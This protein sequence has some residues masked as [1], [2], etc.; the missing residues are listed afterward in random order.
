M[1]E[2]FGFEFKRKG[3]KTEEDIGSFAPKI[4]DEGAITVAEGGAYGT[5]VDLEG[6]TRTESELITRY[7][8][9]ALQPECELAIDDIVNETIVYGEEHKICEVNLDSLE[10]SPK[11][12]ELIREEFDNTLRLLDFNSKGYEIFRHWYIDG[13]LYYHVVVDRDNPEDGVRELRYIDP[14]KIKKIRTVQKQRIGNASAQSGPGAV[15]IQKTKEEYFIYNEKGFT[16]YPGGSPTAAAGEQGVKIARD[17][18]I[19]VTSGMM[20]EDNRIVL[21]HLHKA[22]KPL[23]QLR[24]LEDATVIYRISR[25]PERRVF[26]IDVGNLPKMKAEQYLRDMM[27]KHKNRL[28]YDAGTGEVRDDRKFM[29][30]LEDYWLP[31]R[32]GGRGTEISSLGG[33]QNLGELE[34]VLYFQKKLYRSLNVPVSRLES[35]TGFQLGRST[36]ISRDELKFQK[37]IGRT[38][39]RFSILFNKVLEK[40]L[41]LKGIMTLEEYN[42]AKEFI[43]YDFME[44]NHFSELKEMEIQTERVNALNNI[45]PF[46]GRYFSQRWAK[47]NILRMTDEQME[48]MDAE[49]AEEQEDGTI[50]QDLEPAGKEAQP[51]EPMDDQPPEEEPPAQEL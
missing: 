9:M 11:L 38:R 50:H 43:R 44:D 41:V 13:R 28:V 27:V 21:S 36:E 5:Y 12:K 1:A 6:S 24:I 16:G 29:T 8:R 26:Y 32:E 10:G 45:D 40:Q 39:N 33:G 35:E 14:R 2:L 47:K 49:I 42:E 23:N 7:R 30:M 4:D 48:Q 20:S 51:E 34:D 19:N 46:I 25:A 18:V 37:F 17:S 15:T 3:V 31:R 22:I